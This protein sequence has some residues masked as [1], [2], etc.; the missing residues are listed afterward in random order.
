[1][2][3][4]YFVRHAQPDYND[5]D[6]MLR[7]LTE[8]GLRDCAL[9]REYLSGKEISRVYSSPFKRAVDTVRGFAECAGLDVTCVEAFRERRIAEEWIEDFRAYAQR[10]WADFDFSLPGGECL[11][12]VQ[13]RNIAALN[14]L[15]DA[16]PGE[17]IAIGS[18]GTALSTILHYYD[19]TFGYERFL[20]IVGLMPW[21]VH[22][23]FDGGKCVGVES[24]DL[25]RQR[26]SI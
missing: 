8:K 7:P 18:H 13:E 21:I 25:F 14:A 20:E 19:D 4:V 15:L 3:N 11:R 26:D 9:V 1:M 23:T 5:H 6:D 10:Q 22:F 2:T 16:H 12:E 24:V 17:N